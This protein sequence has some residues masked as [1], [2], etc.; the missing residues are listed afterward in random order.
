MLC[1]GLGASINKRFSTTEKPSHNPSSHP[2]KKKKHVNPQHKVKQ[3]SVIKTTSVRDMEI[4]HVPASKS[5][6]NGEHLYNQM[7]S[8]SLGEFEKVITRLPQSRAARSVCFSW[9]HFI[10]DGG[11]CAGYAGC[12]PN[13]AI[14][15]PTDT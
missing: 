5:L 7:S 10:K 12:A 3:C 2:Q 6:G 14:F 15:T 13:Q 1:Q 11:L 9:Q 4:S 8:E